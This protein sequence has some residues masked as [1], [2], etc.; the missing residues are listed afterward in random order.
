M[1]CGV[2]ARSTRRAAPLPGEGSTHLRGCRSPPHAPIGKS[3]RRPAILHY[4]QW[5]VFRVSKGAIDRLATHVHL[6]SVI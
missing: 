1:A 2:C 5:A 3:P 4:A 6:F